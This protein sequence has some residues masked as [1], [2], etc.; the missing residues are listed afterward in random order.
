[1]SK[2]WSEVIAS[3][4]YQ[5]LSAQ[6]KAAAQSQYFDSVVKPNLKPDEVDAA[7]EQFY[8]QYPVG[9]SSTPTPAPQPTEDKESF[10][11]A[12]H[13]PGEAFSALGNALTTGAAKWLTTEHLG[14]DAGKEVAPTGAAANWYQGQMSNPETAHNA[15][16]VAKE[17]PRA[18]IYGSVA[19]AT[20]GLG[21]PLY[22]AMGAG[23][24]AVPIARLE[25][26]AMGSAASQKYA[27]GDVS[28]K[29]VLFDT[30][31][32]EG[33]HLG[34]RVLGAG[35]K[36]VRN[37]LPE[38]MGGIS[39]AE[40]VA[41]VADPAYVGEAVTGGDSYR[42]ATTDVNGNSIMNPSQAFNAEGGAKYIRAQNR[43]ISR[44]DRSVFNQRTQQQLTG[45]SIGRAIDETGYNPELQQS[46]ERVMEGHKERVNRMYT[47]AKSNAQDILD[48][49][50]VKITELKFP[51]TKELANTHLETSKAN[52]NAF[53]TADA[54]KTL[55]AFKES[56]ITN[57]DELD[58]WKRRLSE[59]SQKAY[60]AGDMDSYRALSSVKNNLR[61][62][63]DDVIHSINPDAASLYSDADRY[64]AQTVEGYGKRSELQ[65][66]INAENDYSAGSR[67]LNRN[68]GQDRTLNLFRDINPKPGETFDFGTQAR[69]ELAQAIG[70]ESRNRAFSEATRG[71]KFSPT[72]F[73]N[74]LR[75]AEDSVNVADLYSPRN[76]YNINASLQDAAERM[77]V[78]NA[79]SVGRG[80]TPEL[81]ANAGR[82]IGGTAG[83]TIGGLVGGPIGAGVG[84]AIGSMLGGP[85]SRVVS[86]GLFDRIIGTNRNA[87][88][89]LNF[90]AKPENAAKVADILQS[91]G[92][93]NASTKAI[94]NV[95]DTITSAAT[96]VY[97]TRAKQPEQ[98][99]Q[100]AYV[101]PE[102]V[103]PEPIQEAQAVK[104]PTDEFDAKTTNLYKALA[105]AETGGLSNRFI[106][107]KSIPKGDVSTAYGPAQ[108]TVGLMETFNKRHRNDLT[109]KEREYVD[110]FIAQG[111]MMKRAANDDPVYGYGGTG[112]LGDA[113]NRRM[114]ANIARKMLDFMIKDNGGSL[115]KTMKQWRGNEKD[116]AYFQK[117]RTHYRSLF[118]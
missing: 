106:R 34:G 102:K 40:K 43:D 98:P 81:S 115:E 80:I 11:Y 110:A 32:G 4:D 57:L 18:A 59:K 3:P 6:D 117:V 97:N 105:H 13:H 116:T 83:T 56:K 31:V 61:T 101:P 113:D 15:D 96:P 7:H 74:E 99:T 19:L 60:K 76:E 29:Q 84:T 104:K 69:N 26:N 16:V 70:G 92:G 44:G 38:S 45:E 78:S 22:E 46:G 58:S 93:L 37:V 17:I 77:K 85:V 79:N 48:Q 66:I 72:V 64:F 118:S 49:A 24:L 68:Y 112:T 35:I 63:A 109:P 14:K 30:A 75:N 52:N 47:D 103:E 71:E 111:N 53:L 91:E 82:I 108:I 89:Y 55:N 25:A 100:S 73:S 94:T 33:L 90:L 88:K 67:L 12:V 8:N 50:P 107:T 28:G 62:E 23:R 10:S 21:V 87:V 65:R 36:A 42:I 51:D 95:I 114:Y 5:N 2:R 9:S 27:D 41:P 1:M 54:R 20:E 86:E 39:M